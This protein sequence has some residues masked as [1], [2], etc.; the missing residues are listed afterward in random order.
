MAKSPSRTLVID[1]SIARAAGS[2]GATHPTSKNCRDVLLLVKDVCHRLVISE[3]IS[4][5]WKDHQS[6]FARRWLVEMFS[7]KKVQRTEPPSEEQVYD[8]V[9]ELSNS[10]A[11]DQ[12]MWKDAHL[13][14]AALDTDQTV[15]SLDEIV[16]E[17]FTRLAGMITQL[18]SIVW[19]NPNRP[20]EN[21]LEWI[22]KGAK[23]DRSRCLGAQPH[24]RS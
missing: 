15:L 11:D 12:A 23:P 10:W 3:R 14:A 16:R 6:T 1:A 18:R 22:K 5:E 17:K 21:V 8:W 2:E 24:G 4:Q 13:L 7:R 19:A 20:E 9:Q